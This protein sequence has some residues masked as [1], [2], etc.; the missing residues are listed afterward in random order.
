MPMNDQ[1]VHES[2]SLLSQLRAVQQSGNPDTIQAFFTE[3]PELEFVDDADSL[4]LVSACLNFLVRQNEALSMLEEI[5]PD[6]LTDASAVADFGLSLFLAKQTDK[7][8][9]ILSEACRRSD[10]PDVAFGRLAVIELTEE[11]IV[12]AA[13]GFERAIDIDPTNARWVN[14]LAGCRFRQRRYQ[15][16][17]DLYDRAL[18]LD[19]GLTL[20]RQMRTRALLALDRADEMIDEAREQLEKNPEIPELL[21]ALALIQKEADRFSQAEATLSAA[22]DRFPERDEFK[23]AIINLLM[24]QQSYNRL[25]LMLKD[26]VEEREEP[27]WTSLALNRVRIEAKYLDTAE[28]SLQD[29]QDTPLADDPQYSILQAKILIERSRGEEAV[30][31][32]ED[33]V[34]RFP[35]NT[36][37]MNLLAQTLTSLGRLEEASAY[38]NDVQMVNPMAILQHIEDQGYKG[39]SGEIMQL[40]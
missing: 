7:A 12:S 20:S 11:N 15:E 37:A 16:A 33:T 25:G 8:K 29:L 4:A 2:E 21:L 14:N 5:D 36:E 3:H 38:Y 27:D 32:L 24:E 26:W 18:V 30:Q 28:E 9:S 19:P 6:K 39:D 10:A 35:G 34:A 31:L 22:I 1:L 17:I 13:L 40:E 23:R